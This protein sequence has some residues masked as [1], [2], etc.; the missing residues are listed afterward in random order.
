MEEGQRD[1]DRKRTWLGTTGI[2]NREGAGGQGTLVACRSW[3]REEADL[4]PE[5]L[6]RNTDPLTP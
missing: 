5:S 4:T 3:K 6:E 2:E 1:N